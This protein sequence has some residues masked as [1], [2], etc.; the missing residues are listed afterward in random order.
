MTY[1]DIVRNKEILEY[2]VRGGKTLDT[3]GYTDHSIAHTKLVAERAADILS[4]FG[5]GQIP[6]CLTCTTV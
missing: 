6:Y 2:Y 3:L 1:K 4:S 5:Y